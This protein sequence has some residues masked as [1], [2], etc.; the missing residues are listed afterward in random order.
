ML[1]EYINIVNGT[2]IKLPIKNITTPLTINW[3]DGSSP[4]TNITTNNPSHT[5]ISNFE[6][7]EVSIVGNFT[8][9]GTDPLL[10][11]IEGIELLSRVISFN[12]T[13]LNSLRGAFYNATS[14]IEVPTTLPSTVTNLDY[15]F[16]NATS[17]NQNIFVWNITNVTTL[18]FILYGAIS[19]NQPITGWLLNKILTFP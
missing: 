11:T 12:I 3:G 7:I 10:E 9:F 8:H 1:L 19:F 18:N 13:S 15:L 6:I 4:E 5:Y 14:L 2:I 17:F 16:F